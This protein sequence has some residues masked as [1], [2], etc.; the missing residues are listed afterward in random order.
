[1][2]STTTSTG[3]GFSTDLFLDN[4][5]VELLSTLDPTNARLREVNGTERI[6]EPFEYQIKLICIDPVQELAPVVGSRMTIGLKLK[7]GSGRYFNGLVTQFRFVGIDNTRR[8][9][10]VAEVRSWLALLDLRQNCRL[11]QNMTALQIIKAI[12]ADHPSALFTDDTSATDM[13]VRPLCV[14]WN[15]TDL[16]FVTRL[17]E[18]EGIYYYFEHTIDLHELVLVNNLSAHTPCPGDDLILTHLNLKPAQIYNDVIYNWHEVAELQP[19]LVVLND[20]DFEKPPTDLLKKEPVP[21]LSAE[22]TMAPPAGETNLEIYGYPGNYHEPM[23]GAGYARIRA[24]EMAC[25][26]VRAWIES[27]ARNLVPGHTF[28]AENPFDR[29]ECVT[30]PEN[31]RNYL[32][33]GGKF[34][35]VVEAGAER[36]STDPH[37]LFNATMEALL[38]AIQYRPP[39]RTPRPAIAGPQ[40]ALVVGDAGEDI[41]T[42]KYGRIKVQFYWDREGGRNE[43]SS[44]FIRVAQNWAG[45]SWGGLVT[46]RIGQEVV[47]QFLNGDPDWPIITG[48][49]YNAQNMP[50]YDLPL[51]ATRS[52]FKTR[53]S[54]TPDIA[55]NELRFEDRSGSEE[56]YLRAQKDL[57]GDVRNDFTVVTGS[58]AKITAKTSTTIEAA[59]VPDSAMGSS[60]EV[61]SA[62]LVTVSCPTNI[63]L[64]VGPLGAPIASIAINETGITLTGVKIS[65]SV[66]PTIAP[67]IPPAVPPLPES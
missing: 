57:N 5:Y 39:R 19:E 4:R 59:A 62:G 67:P 25:R 8:A 31:P 60:V 9:N 20:Y 64:K 63:L 42:D 45:R 44:P 23:H 26:T 28:K 61:E 47:V 6:G 24:E 35:I 18:Q 13:R 53:S 38:A 34:S 37:F 54:I 11:F 55:Y 41:T 46:P 3:G 22:G 43:N 14:Q 40:T 17:M 52:T 7:D 27:T 2:S 36:K 56:V 58:K 49:V 21:R 65:L 48:T 30:D 1:M 16:A 15:E 66:P 50:P 32:L 29:T 12:F 33:L 51:E 10:Y